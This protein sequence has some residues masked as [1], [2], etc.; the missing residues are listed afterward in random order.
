MFLYRNESGGA[1]LGKRGPG[2]LSSINTSVFVA[3][4]GAFVVIKGS[5]RSD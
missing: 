5:F 4:N 1:G 2:L 3:I